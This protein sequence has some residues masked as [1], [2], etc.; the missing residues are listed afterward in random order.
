VVAYNKNLIS[1]DKVPNRWEDFLKPEFKER[2]FVVD[3]RPHAFA[4]FPACLQEASV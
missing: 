3:M 2:K 1:P 4:A